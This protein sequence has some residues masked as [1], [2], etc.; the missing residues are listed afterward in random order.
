M[1]YNFLS[2]GWLISKCSR[3]TKDWKYLPFKIT[4]QNQYLWPHFTARET[5]ERRHWGC[6]VEVTGLLAPTP[7]PALHPGLAIV[8]SLHL[9]GRGTGF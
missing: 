2:D 6:T 1:Y 9:L 4:L 3:N 8:I 7:T 5:N